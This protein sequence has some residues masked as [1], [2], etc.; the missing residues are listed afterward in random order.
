[1]G[2]TLV[3]LDPMGE[4]ATQDFSLAP[5][6]RELRGKTLG[7][8]DNGMPGSNAIL[9]GLAVWAIP[10]V[11]ALAVFP[12]RES[13]RAFFES[14]MPVT[15]TFATMLFTVRYFRRIEKNFVKEGI[16]LGVI[17]LIVS[18]ALDLILFSKGPMA[19]PF[20]AY[21][22]DIGFTYLLETMITIGA[23]YL[24]EK[25]SKRTA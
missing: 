4:V 20:V 10:F 21:A 19:M 16:R 7:I 14:I 9:S 11:V 24:L 12:L 15:V 3:I 5:R 13:D 8:I 22:K 25:S 17:F 6:L 1:M 2:A 23:G 18:V